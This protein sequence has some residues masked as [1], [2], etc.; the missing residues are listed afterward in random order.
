MRAYYYNEDQR[1]TKTNN[2]QILYSV[3]YQSLLLTNGSYEH[4]I[5]V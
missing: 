4:T 2:D 1:M 3:Y 5:V